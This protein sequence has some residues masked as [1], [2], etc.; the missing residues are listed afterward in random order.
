[1]GKYGI[2]IL[3]VQETRRAKAEIFEVNGYQVILS[4]DDSDEQVWAGVGFFI[5]P[6]CQQL[7]KAYKQIS[8][9]LA[10]I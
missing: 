7:V 1:M 2:D 5:S 4:V 3:A 8:D 6:S 10:W 9:I